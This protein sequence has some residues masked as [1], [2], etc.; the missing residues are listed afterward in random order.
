[1]KRVIPYIISILLFAGIVDTI[2]LLKIDTDL[3]GGRREVP[4]FCNV[5]E[6]VNCDASSMSEYS[7]FLG[8]RN[9]IWGLTFYSVFFIFSLLIFFLG[10]KLKLILKRWIYIYGLTSFLM[11][12]YFAYISIFVIKAFCLLCCVT[13]ILNLAIILFCYIDLK[14]NPILTVKLFFKQ[15]LKAVGGFFIGKSDKNSIAAT[16]FISVFVLGALGGL[17]AGTNYFKKNTRTG[18]YSKSRIIENWDKQ[19]AYDF[20]VSQTTSSWGKKDAKVKI[21]EFSDFQCPFCRRAAFLLKTLLAQYK[22]Q[23]EL[24]FKN[25]PLDNSCNPKVSS[26]YHPDA[27]L[28]SKAAI[29]A[30]SKGKLWEFHD[31][32]FENSKSISRRKI[33]NFAQKM[34]FTKEEFGKCLDSPYAQEIIRKEIEDAEKFGVKATP[35]FIINGRQIRG[36][37]PPEIF[38]IIIRYELDR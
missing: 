33:L 15:I 21:I 7:T 16:I 20:T 8:I 36:L 28:M 29:C 38:Q 3:W 30:D 11:S 14:E 4:S 9:S 34:G 6:F 10:S 12:L 18:K 19:P 25:Y 24:V 26:S 27:C 23:V 17:W 35:T 37:K 1:M 2:K 31:Y 32:L 5:S 22:N 13:Y